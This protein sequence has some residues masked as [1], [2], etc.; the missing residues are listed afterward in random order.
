MLYDFISILSVA[1]VDLPGDHD[2]HAIVVIAGVESEVVEEVN[3]AYKDIL[4]EIGNNWISILA[5]AG[6]PMEIYN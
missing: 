6:S 5:E 2:S 3:D 1:T 4:E